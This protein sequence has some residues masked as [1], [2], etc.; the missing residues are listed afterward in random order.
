MKNEWEEYLERLWC[1]REEG[2]AAESELAG[3]MDGQFSPESLDELERES[4]IRRNGEGGVVL[5]DRGINRA[6]DLIRAH[7]IG[8]RLIHDVLGK[9]FEA[10]A[11]EFEHTIT[12]ELVDSICTLLGH[13]RECPH[14]MPI[15]EGEC[16]RQA[17]KAVRTAVISLTDLEIGQ[18]ARVA[19][20]YAASD[21]ELHIVDSL[22]IKPGALVK[23]HQKFP[24]FVIECEGGN[25]AID[26]SIASNIRVWSDSRTWIADE[27]VPSDEASGQPQRGRGRHRRFGRR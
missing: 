23:L 7:R 4:L 21:S 6:R 8:E 9:D 18:S 24:T 19:Y 26:E 10:G 27:D 11:C 14:G 15:P 22:Q 25:I 17:A 12:T 20:I 3:R 2:E 1:M 5:T 13:P 16:C